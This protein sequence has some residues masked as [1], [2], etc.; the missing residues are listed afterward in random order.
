METFTLLWA[1]VATKPI[2]FNANESEVRVVGTIP[3]RLNLRMQ[4]SLGFR[5]H[6]FNSPYSR[7]SYALTLIQSLQTFN[8][9]RASS[10]TE[11]RGVGTLYQR[12]REEAA[13]VP[14]G[15]PEKIR[16]ENRSICQ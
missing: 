15:T 7:L 14:M 11:P 4:N 12:L 5:R 8:C 3:A 16:E 9:G 1:G 2:A 13:A 6:L 10:S